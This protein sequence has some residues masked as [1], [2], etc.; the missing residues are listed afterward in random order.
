[1]CAEA[2]GHRLMMDRIVPGGVTTDLSAAGKASIS[3]LC[4]RL[5]GEF[6]ELIELYENTASLQ[7]RTVGT[8]VLTSALAAQ[9][10]AGGYVGRAS[11]RAFDARSILPYAPYDELSVRTC[12]RT[13]GDVDARLWIR[14]VEVQESVRWLQTALTILPSGPIRVSLP[15]PGTGAAVEST[16]L[17]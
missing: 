4:Q 6:P 16:A 5:H 10:A 15:T 8:G 3:A 7:D 13:E 14:I 17:V 1:V 9:F 12:S 11:G 2:F